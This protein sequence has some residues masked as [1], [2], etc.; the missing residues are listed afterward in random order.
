MPQKFTSIGTPLSRFFLTVLLALIP[1]AAGAAHSPPAAFDEPAPQNDQAAQRYLTALLRNPRPGPAF[2]RVYAWHADR[3]SAGQFH[4]A[5]LQFAANAGVITADSPSLTAPA[6]PPAAAPP[7]VLT[8][9][10]G[11]PPD[12]ALLLAGLIDLRHGE[13][14][15]SVKLLA[16]AAELRPNDPAA[17]WMLARALDQADQAAAAAAAFDAALALKPARADLAEIHRDYAESLQRQRKLDEALIV[18]QRLEKAFPGDRRV[19]R[20]VARA[21][22]RG[23]RWTDALP[24]YEQLAETADQTEERITAELEVCDALQQLER[25]PEA[26]SRLQNLLPELDPAAWLYRDVRTRIE[27]LHR[28]TGDLAGL[29]RLYETWL[30][31]HPEDLDVMQRLARVLQEQGRGEEA[32]QW[33]TRALARAPENPQLRTA[34]TAALQ[35]AGR[36]AEAATQLQQWLQSGPADAQQWQQLGLLQLSRTELAPAER[37]SL[38]ASAF[39]EFTRLAADDPRRLRQAAE[40][41]ERA[42][43]PERAE[44]LL[45]Q[46]LTESPDDPLTRETLGSLLQR[47]Q[48]PVEALQVWSELAAGPRRNPQSLGQLADLLQRNGFP[49][50]AIAAGRAAC[51]LAPELSDRLR[52]VELLLATAGNG[53]PQAQELFREALSQ[54]DLADSAAAEAFERERVLELRVRTLL[55]SD[56]LMQALGTERQRIRERTAAGTITIADY[57][58]L[59]AFETAAGQISAAAAACLQ[60]VQLEPDA[61]ADW[62][63]LVQLCERAGQTGDA[64]AA[65]KKLMQLDRRGW[66]GYQR[67]LVRLE[68]QQGR[69]EA[70]L[71]AATE[72]TRAT[73]GNV[74]AWQFLAETAF[75]AG[76]A[77]QGVE[78]LRRAVRSSPGD[79]T[80]LR[81]LART[82]ADEFQTAEALELTW[83]AFEQ[84]GD[85]QERQELAVFLAQLALRSSR[86]TATHQRLEQWLRIH[87]DALEAARS[88]AAF[89]REAGRFSEARAVL[90]PLLHDDPQNST[91]LGELATL[92]ERERRGDLAS[93]YLLRLYRSTASLQ[94]LRRLLLLEP[95]LLKQAGID[96]SQLLSEAALTAASRTDFH[97]VIQLAV[98]RQLQTVALQLCLE[99]LEQDR[100]DWWSLHQAA[101][102][103]AVASDT[104]SQKLQLQLLN[105]PLSTASTP[106]VSQPVASTPTGP[107]ASQLWQQAAVV[108]PEAETT[109]AVF[110]EAL[111]L[112][113]RSQLR[114]NGAAGL[115]AVLDSVAV[116]LH[117]PE[118]LAACA[119]DSRGDVLS[120]ESLDVLLQW[121]GKHAEPPAA[122]LRLKLLQQRLLLARRTDSSSVQADLEQQ[123]VSQAVSLLEQS[124][125]TLTESAV[126]D[127][128][129][130]RSSALDLWRA[131]LRKLASA[132]DTAQPATA[133]PV[134]ADRLPALLEQAVLLR[135][136]Q[137]FTALLGRFSA[138]SLT[139]AQQL[140]MQRVCERPELAAWVAELSEL[141]VLQQLLQFL[142]SPSVWT[143]SELSVRLLTAGQPGALQFRYQA[144]SAS[145]RERLISACLGRSLQLWRGTVE[146]LWRDFFGSQPDVTPWSAA[147]L[148]AELQRQRGA[149]DPLLRELAVAADIDRSEWTLRLWLAELLPGLGLIDEA[150]ELLNRL[151]RTDAKAAIEAELLALNICLASDRQ[152]RAREAA[153]RLSGLP[154]SEAQQQRLVPVLGRLQL[155]DVLR[156]VEVR[157]GRS[158]ETRTGLLARRLQAAQAA[159][160][161]PLAGELAWE[162]LRLSSGGSLF[163]G[164]RP[165]DDRDDGGERVLALRALAQCGRAAELAER[166]EAMLTAAPDALP[167]L[168]LLAELDDAAGNRDQLARRQDQIAALTGRASPGRRRRAMELENTGD[169]S[170]ACDEYLEILRE[171]AAT[172]AAEAETF[173]QAFE[174]AKRVDDFLRGVMQ[175]DAVFWQQNGRLLATAT[176]AAARKL[177]ELAAANDL[178]QKAAARLL[179]ESDTRR[180]GL[181]MLMNQPGLLTDDQVRVGFRAELERLE[182]PEQ[183]T[184]TELL[185][186]CSEL[187]QLAA[188]LERREL[189]RDLAAGSGQPVRSAAARIFSL[190]VTAQLGEAALFEEAAAQLMAD[191]RSA[192]SETSELFTELLVLLQQRLAGLGADWMA[193]RERLLR[194]AL[195]SGLVQGPATEQLRLVLAELLQQSGRSSEARQLLLARL[196]AT[197]TSAN[198]TSAAGVRELLKTA[199]QVQH[200]GYPVEAAELLCGLSQ[201]DLQQFTKTLEQD[202]AAAFRSRWNAA[203]Q[204]SVRQ[205]TAERLV[206]WLET[207]LEASSAEASSQPA[208]RPRNTLLLIPDGPGDPAETNPERLTQLVVQS[209]LLEAAWRGEFASGELREKLRKL[210][211]RLLDQSVDDIGLLCAA[212]AFA[213][214]AELTNERDRLIARLLE[215][216]AVPPPPGQAGQLQKTQGDEFA[217][218]QIAGLVEFGQRLLADGRIDQTMAER[219]WEAAVAVTERPG[220]RLVRLAVLN[221]AAGAAARAGLQV[222]AERY[223]GKA[224]EL[225]TE[226]QQAGGRTRADVETLA[227][228]VRRLLQSE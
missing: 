13:P 67:Q 73:P 29:T 177:D 4:A 34:F 23:G 57:R 35:S 167:L 170:A 45:R 80:A 124:P 136:P 119:A 189:L 219:L 69:P 155:P 14:Q 157:L 227:E 6:E 183:L 26:L 212:A 128:R 103:A 38:A 162:L 109:P 3:G 101:T 51:S 20:Q 142:F 214:R 141:S 161:Q 114:A 181:A 92:A 184:Q 43:R 53:N 47:R 81:S 98:S 60:V 156:S 194:L 130:L 201:H 144:G 158:T 215:S 179:A 211:G 187:L 93:E 78:A 55:A 24:R 221:R 123:L 72:L 192:F 143:E 193:P 62:S 61:V 22:A 145:P 25:R 199:E 127:P 135:D 52:F 210:T 94:D 89:E 37:Q 205:M 76:K 95:T 180:L 86:W 164:F 83:R 1:A 196:L 217:G 165:T 174:R 209:L 160:N 5:L 27:Q 85:A 206:A 30:T 31:S 172:F 138:A 64:T 126:F 118:L 163:S 207:Q 154:L 129:Q 97:A 200:S 7:Q 112:A 88:V 21:L 10:P 8:L 166:Y 39:E 111:V 147:L 159:G 218:L 58:R 87:P 202:R 82:L 2:E 169:V 168:E 32:R 17:H 75:A 19:L 188:S 49:D 11:S 225:V 54:L 116:R 140:R 15:S 208:S 41:L 104:T 222:V 68:L 113:I 106:A 28:S 223:R 56:G 228:V 195:E 198:G 204:W 79:V 190:A 175:L 46:L 182:R 96:P 125:Q 185:A 146:E 186:A 105:L 9:P 110:A 100:D 132:A 12:A 139:T 70:A 107:E 151:P 133:Q 176:A 74:D 197:G 77:D 134:I 224:D 63:L 122:G 152:E 173:Y 171:D 121:L 216:S 84:S 66:S 191:S 102:L 115:P 148:R 48:R 99:R 178:V 226:Q 213:D 33:L 203:V 40:L 44:Q 50:E 150:L 90:E 18:W 36:A 71:A 59:C 131:G 91:L 16:R 108:V 220:A 137:L 42:G 149:L 65:L 153:V 120:A 117:G